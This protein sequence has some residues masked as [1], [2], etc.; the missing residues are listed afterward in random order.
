MTPKWIQILRSV[1]SS[2]AIARDAVTVVFLVGGSRDFLESVEVPPEKA[3]Q[4]LLSLIGSFVDEAPDEYVV[5]LSRCGIIHQPVVR[6][7]PAAYCSAS[8]HAIHSLI[9]GRRTVVVEP[10]F[11]VEALTASSLASYFY[12]HIGS[13]ICAGRFSYRHGRYR[14]FDKAEKDFIEG[15]VEF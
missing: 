10:E 6:L 12:D 2:P 13:E 15:S 11:A 8:P 5:S 7:V 3:L 4:E 1:S 14:P 9:Q